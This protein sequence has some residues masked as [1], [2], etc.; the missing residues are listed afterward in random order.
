MAHPSGNLA[1]NIYV[2]NSDDAGL[3]SPR[4][5]KFTSITCTTVGTGVQVTGGGIFVNIDVSAASNVFQKFIDPLTGV[6]FVSDAA[7][8]ATGDGYYEFVSSEAT[9]LTMIAGQTIYGRFNSVRGLGGQNG[10]FTGF[11]YAG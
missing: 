6:A 8:T 1:K 3:A 5:G 4:S 9:T 11:A 10:T 2:I 7:M